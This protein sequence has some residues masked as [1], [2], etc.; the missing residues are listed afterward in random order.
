MNICQTCLSVA[1]AAALL[2]C[3]STDDSGGS[4][5][6]TPLTVAGFYEARAELGCT[7]SFECC[8]TTGDDAT[9][10]SNNRQGATSAA[11]CASA[12]MHPTWESAS[13]FVQSDVESG[14]II[15]HG[16]KAAECIAALAQLSCRE[17]FNDEGQGEPAP[18]QATFEGTIALG[19]ACE[20]SDECEDDMGCIG[21]T[22]SGYRCK[23]I[24]G[25]GDPCTGYCPY[26]YYCN[27]AGSCAA[28]LP[29]GASCDPYSF[30]QCQGI[31]SYDTSTCG[32][33]LEFT[34]ACTG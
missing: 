13:E 4:A 15:F 7:R 32:P 1:F 11:E 6:A 26:G 22:D 30:L 25:P 2:A 28:Q 24:P 33:P 20:I 14:T 17:Q 31:C 3:S 16:D 18:C 27:D 12:P 10:A 34:P 8:G 23:V 9:I 5:P 19:G 29:E 21:S